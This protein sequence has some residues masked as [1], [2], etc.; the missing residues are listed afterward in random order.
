MMV[1]H[2]YYLWTRPDEKFKYEMRLVLYE[3]R[4]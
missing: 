4:E 1:E 2:H 3:A